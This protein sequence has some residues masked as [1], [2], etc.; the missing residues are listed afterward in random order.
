MI[1]YTI[2]ICSGNGSEAVE[3]LVLQLHDKSIE[4]R[5]IILQ[6]NHVKLQ[7]QALLSQDHSHR[8]ERETLYSLLAQAE[9]DK[10]L[11]EV[12]VNFITQ[13]AAIVQNNYTLIFCETQAKVQDIANF[14]RTGN[15]NLEI[16]EL[17][18]SLLDVA[19]DKV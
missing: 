18:G 19:N 2:F 13:V 14:E 9:Q 8:S 1:N 5:A 11:L 6:L 17:R 15:E 12:R 10:L 3:R 7:L 16:S 4:N